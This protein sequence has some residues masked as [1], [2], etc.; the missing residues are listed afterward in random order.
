VCGKLFDDVVSR[1][2][3]SDVDDLFELPPT[4]EVSPCTDEE[5]GKLTESVLLW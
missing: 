1:F 2:Q 3:L 5:D 4:D